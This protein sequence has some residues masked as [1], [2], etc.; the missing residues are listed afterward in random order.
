MDLL[1]SGLL[2]DWLIDY[3]LLINWLTDWLTDS[4]IDWFIDKLIDWLTRVSTLTGHDQMSI[5]MPFIC[6]HSSNC[7]RSPI[8]IISVTP[9]ALTHW[10]MRHTLPLSK[11]NIN[12]V[13]QLKYNSIWCSLAY[14]STI[15]QAQYRPNFEFTTDTPYLTPSWASYRTFIAKVWEKILPVF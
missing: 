9:H 14:S 8:T 5:C 12:T 4:L 13:L 11:Q 10:L 15:T 1:A 3:N 7:R 6:H 2:I